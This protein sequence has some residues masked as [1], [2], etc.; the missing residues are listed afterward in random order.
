MET[1][2]V[3]KVLSINVKQ[4]ALTI[5]CGQ[6]APCDLRFGP[7]VGPHCQDYV[8]NRQDREFALLLLALVAKMRSVVREKGGG[9][10]LFAAE[11]IWEAGAKTL[12]KNKTS[13]YE[14]DT[15]FFR[16]GV[17]DIWKRLV[18]PNGK[19]CPYG[20]DDLQKG[21]QRLTDIAKR[22]RMTRE[23]LLRAIFVVESVPRATKTENGW[24]V[25]RV[26]GIAPDWDVRIHALETRPDLEDIF[27]LFEGSRVLE[28]ILQSGL[29]RQRA[30]NDAGGGTTT[31]GLLP[32]SDAYIRW[33]DSAPFLKPPPFSLHA[34]VLPYHPMATPQRDYRAIATGGASPVA[35]Q[36]PSAGVAQPFLAAITPLTRHVCIV[37]PS[38]GGKT[39]V[40]KLYLAEQVQK[41]LRKDS[42]LVP[43]FVPVTS[44]YAPPEELVLRALRQGGIHL[45]SLAELGHRTLV[46]FDGI[47]S[48][49]LPDAISFDM[50]VD[51]MF[52]LTAGAWVEQVVVSCTTH[53]WPHEH[54]AARG[55]DVFTVLP[56]DVEIDGKAHRYL[57]QRLPTGIAN[58]L[59]NVIR[60]DWRLFELAANPQ[61]LDL[62][63]SVVE[64]GAS[65][66]SMPRRRSE[67]VA[68]WVD[69]HV[70]LQRVKGWSFESME[71]M[72]VIATVLTERGVLDATPQDLD[73]IALPRDIGLLDALQQAVQVGLLENMGLPGTIDRFRF[74]HQTF[75]EYF[76]ALA[77]RRKVMK[78]DGESLCRMTREYRWDE[79]LLLAVEMLP[80]KA[81]KG[82]IDEILPVDPVLAVRAE[83]RRPEMDRFRSGA[84]L[85]PN[86]SR[87]AL[88]SPQFSAAAF[89]AICLLQGDGAL[90]TL[91]DILQEQQEDMGRGLDMLIDRPHV[92]LA[93][94]ALVHSVHRQRV[95]DVVLPRL[96]ESHRDLVRDDIL[97]ICQDPQS[98][99]VSTYHAIRAVAD[100]P[101][102]KS[103]VLQPLE[104]LLRNGAA[105]IPL[106]AAAAGTLAAL[107]PEVAEPILMELI[108][109]PSVS[110]S[111]L[112]DLL[113]LVRYEIAGRLKIWALTEGVRSVD[114]VTLTS[115]EAA[116]VGPEL[117]AIFCSSKQDRNLRL[118][119]GGWLL[120]GRCPGYHITSARD[121][122]HAWL[123]RMRN[124]RAK[125][126][127]AALLKIVRGG[128]VEL[129][130]LALK[131]LAYY[132]P[133][134]A[135]TVAMALGEEPTTDN[136]LR[137]VALGLIGEIGGE[138]SLPCV[139]RCA[140]RGSKAA[141]VALDRMAQERHILIKKA[142]VSTLQKAVN[143]RRGDDWWEAKVLSAIRGAGFKEEWL[144]R[145]IDKHLRR[146]GPG[147]AI[148]V[149]RAVI[150]LSPSDLAAWIRTQ[151]K[152]RGKDGH[153]PYLLRE[154]AR[155]DDPDDIDFFE[156]VVDEDPDLIDE[157]EIVAFL[158]K[159]GRLESLLVL[160]KMLRCN[161]MDGV[162]KNMARGSIAHIFKRLPESEKDA[163]M[164]VIADASGEDV[165]YLL[166]YWDG[167]PNR[168][169]VPG[170]STGGKQPTKEPSQTVPKAKA[171]KGL[172]KRG[173]SPSRI[174]ARG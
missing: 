168:R 81:V 14:E 36:T 158:H 67:L 57:R 20:F 33:A 121:P 93:L 25:A 5:D 138:H 11:E 22:L 51:Q 123:K 161:D 32:W 44:E 94:A 73:E 71:A 29:R 49:R 110:R 43:L 39:T 96:I 137:D 8:R 2:E 78:G 133:V 124:V 173:Q 170:V 130:S 70:K 10:L 162:C 79:P 89:E 80:S 160:S 122:A 18:S 120:W 116:C 104:R 152:R 128:D 159:H 45:T 157:V 92:A 55:I 64:S 88:R 103:M 30:V 26:Y 127:E 151:L 147:D 144:G 126:H 134:K 40:L 139:V 99:T 54:F 145:A 135:E 13:P 85:L 113:S 172:A 129:A 4:H 146:I 90:A 38:G 41:F 148:A 117:A 100:M 28:T 12:A 107:S 97:A 114:E 23:H 112:T 58:D 35:S 84:V 66:A 106:R 119:A 31:P 87:Q 17:R 7:R 76:A 47:N 75:Q 34:D 102:L 42:V 77:I 68:R 1:R 56:F 83:N 132:H 37:G 9:R 69:R 19:S 163:A 155:L 108:K 171:Q 169:H 115:S 16:F 53:A 82:V 101:D 166:A 109:S 141:A 3:C 154:L 95:V 98:D 149:S 153:P 72:E 105:G 15:G 65:L 27:A 111:E 140:S 24:E 91:A 165:N 21:E 167:D 86:L 125:D 131:I 59:I 48:V 50:Y 63:C 156:S 61:M 136:D 142:D 118:A 60:N 52:A 150:L 74:I 6:G 143:A 62:L 164:K 174:R 46:I